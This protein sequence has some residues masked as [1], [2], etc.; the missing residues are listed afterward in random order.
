MQRRMWRFGKSDLGGRWWFSGKRWRRRQRRRGRR[1]RETERRSGKRGEGLSLAASQEDEAGELLR[2]LGE[3]VLGEV[4]S[5][6]VED[7]ESVH[8]EEAVAGSEWEVGVD[9]VEEKA[10]LRS[11]AHRHV[12]RSHLRLHCQHLV[13]GGIPDQ[14]VERRGIPTPLLFSPSPSSRR[15]ARRVPET[16]NLGQEAALQGLLPNAESIESDVVPV[17]NVSPSQLIPDEKRSHGVQLEMLQPEKNVVELP[18]CEC[19]P[20]PPFPSSPSG[21][22]RR[23]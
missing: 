9:S 12:S 3:E 20:P 6:G 17:C 16:L 4:E 19:F 15:R 22:R 21:R 1:G 2:L 18:V 13:E 7:A 14:I 5:A 11:L 23:N 8:F 10:A